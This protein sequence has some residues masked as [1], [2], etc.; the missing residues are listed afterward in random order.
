MQKKKTVKGKIR[1]LPVKQRALEK[2]SIQSI[3]AKKIQYVIEKNVQYLG[4]NVRVKYLWHDRYRINVFE[5]GVVAQSYY[6]RATLDGIFQSTP[7]LPEN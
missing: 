3:V 6:V 5:N 4:K 7:P 1:N 2:E